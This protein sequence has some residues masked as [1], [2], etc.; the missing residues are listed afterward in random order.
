MKQVSEAQPVVFSMYRKVLLFD[1]LIRYI[2]F[3]LNL[4]KP[5][6]LSKLI[7]CG[8]LYGSVYTLLSILLIYVRGG[9]KITYKPLIILMI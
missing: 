7:V 2:E 1:F 8:F 5:Y 9:M 4:T 3:W 6:M